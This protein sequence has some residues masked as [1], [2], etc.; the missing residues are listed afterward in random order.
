MASTSAPK[1]VKNTKT[2]LFILPACTKSMGEPSFTSRIL[3]KLWRTIFLLEN[4]PDSFLMMWWLFSCFLVDSGLIILWCVSN[5]AS[6]ELRIQAIASSSSVLI[7][8]IPSRNTRTKGWKLLS[9]SASTDAL[10]FSLP[11]MKSISSW[12]RRRRSGDVSVFLPW[13][14]DTCN[15]S[16]RIRIFVTNLRANELILAFSFLLLSTNSSK[17][18]SFSAA[19]SSSS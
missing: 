12:I 3:E 18:Y 16:L 14:A 13:I 9:K 19:F 2:C 6:C 1:Q 5:I 4:S 15:R 17:L 10:I 7:R 11:A 8:L